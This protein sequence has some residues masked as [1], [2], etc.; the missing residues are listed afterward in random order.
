MEPFCLLQQLIQQ[1]FR[2]RTRTTQRFV[3]LI[4]SHTK[5]DAQ[6]DKLAVVVGRTKLTALAT[7]DVTWRIFLSLELQIQR[8]VLLFSQIREFP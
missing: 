6:C 2:R 5:V 3:I 8:K 7:V 4:A 1:I